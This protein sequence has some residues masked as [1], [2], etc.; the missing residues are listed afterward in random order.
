M[1]FLSQPI[2]TKLIRFGLVGTSGVFVDF[3]VTW[4]C[5]EKLKLGKYVANSLG[6]ICAVV[7]NYTL[8]RRWTFHNTDP[9]LFTQFGKFFLVSLVGLFLSNCLIYVFHER[10]RYNFYLSKAVAILIVMIW[11]FLAN[12]YF[13]FRA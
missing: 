3:G 6:F 5:K 1:D 8:N 4:L 11:N 12:Y 2:I 10:L 13:T 9:A 7:S